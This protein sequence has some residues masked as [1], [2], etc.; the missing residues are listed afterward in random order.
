[1]MNNDFLVFVSLLCI[2]RVIAVIDF[3][4]FTPSTIAAAAVIC[5]AGEAG[6]EP[7]VFHDSL[8][9]V[10]AFSPSSF[11]WLECNFLFL[12]GSALCAKGII[13]IE[14]NSNTWF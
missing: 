10:R 9:G 13:V 6:D 14:G 8:D 2:G 1:M 5:A 3:L 4:G 7:P 12:I 11:L